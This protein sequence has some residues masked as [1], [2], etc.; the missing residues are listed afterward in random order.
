M[1]AQTVKLTIL[2]VLLLAAVISSATMTSSYSTYDYVTRNTDGN[3]KPVSVTVMVLLE[4]ATNWNG[5]PPAHHTAHVSVTFGG[6]GSGNYEGPFNPN[7]N[8]NVSASVTLEDTATC[9]SDS[10]AGCLISVDEGYVDCSVAGL[11][12]FVNGAYNGTGVC[13]VPTSETTL[14]AGTDSAKG[15][16]AVTEFA[17]TLS[18]PYSDSFDGQLVQ[19]LAGARGS[20]TCWW[21]GN[22]INLQQY[23]NVAGST[24]TVASGDLAG[25]HNKW[26]YD[27]VGYLS[28]SG[29]A[30]I[31]S[32]GPA[33]GVS[34]PCTQTLY[35]VMEIYCNGVNPTIYANDILTITVNQGTSVTNC[36]AGVCGTINGY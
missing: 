13:P 32:N 19:E 22:G 9:F 3:G 29:P 11:F 12:Y 20:D 5:M 31:R 34:I 15:Y 6:V 24:W 27:D 28:S 2:V 7:F 35:Q 25:V 17:Q 14:M 30:Y 21:S 33:H 26:G 8:M 10:D 23:P 1:K 36:R 16:P 18:D 4:G